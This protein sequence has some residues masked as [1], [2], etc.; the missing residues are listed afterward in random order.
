MDPKS[1]SNLDPQQPDTYNNGMG[2][3]DAGVIPQQNTFS[4]DT[5]T[6]VQTDTLQ[7]NISPTPLPDPSLQN[8]V[9]TQPE[10]PSMMPT[11]DFAAPPLQADDTPSSP[12]ATGYAEQ[13]DPNV[14][15]PSMMSQTT[16][17]TI[18]AQQPPA[19]P[20][21]PA[22]PTDFSSENIGA[23]ADALSAP[24]EAGPQSSIFSSTPEMT[25]DAVNPA[26]QTESPSAFFTDTAPA[27]PE[28]PASPDAFAPL[29]SAPAP[30]DTA[31]ATDAVA[32]PTPVTPYNT[33]VQPENPQQEAPSQFTQPLPS[34]SEV[35]NENT[36]HETPLI[37]R[38]IYIIAGVIFFVVY[39][40]FWIK[41]LNLPFIF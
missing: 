8:P 20:A 41:L 29:S 11:P 5:T 38:V 10:N 27:N 22:A 2:T 31:M 24:M 9:M 1:F 28:Q 16:T 6:T 26:P 37:N 39:T 3:P 14:M 18:T 21:F 33:P 7:T 35:V 17:E 4:T 40:I 13:P 32:D 15:P 30:A 25:P 19:A 34:P 23:P 36:P 12:F